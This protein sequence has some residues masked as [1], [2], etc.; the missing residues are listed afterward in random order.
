MA[1]TFVCNKHF[2]VRATL[3]FKIKLFIDLGLD[4]TLCEW[5]EV[6]N[7]TNYENQVKEA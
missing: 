4:I 6:F 5:M 2:H 3:K 7:I 1:G